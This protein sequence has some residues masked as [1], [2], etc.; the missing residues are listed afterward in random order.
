MH[1]PIDDPSP[2][3]G[4]RLPY[5]LSAAMIV[6][7]KMGRTRTGFTFNILDAYDT[8]VPSYD[9]NIHITAPH[10][11]KNQTTRVS[12]SHTLGVIPMPIEGIE[13]SIV[14]HYK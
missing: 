12:S 6:A 14:S 4:P 13:I 1:A 11:L 2:K 3:A 8:M 5:I 10:I 9:A 7:I